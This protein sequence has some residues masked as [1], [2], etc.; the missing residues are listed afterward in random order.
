[1]PLFPSPSIF[2]AIGT[3][4]GTFVG[5]DGASEGAIFV[6]AAL[7][8][9]L[10]APTVLVG[11]IAGMLLLM[12]GATTA[13][14]RVAALGPNTFDKT[15]NTRPATATAIKIHQSQLQLRA[16]LAG[17]LAG[18]LVGVFGAVGDG[19][20]GLTGRVRAVEVVAVLRAAGFLPPPLPGPVVEVVLTLTVVLVVAAP[21][22]GWGVGRFEP[23]VGLWPA[24]GFA[25]LFPFAFRAAAV[26][27]AWLVAAG[28][29][30]VAAGFVRFMFFLSGMGGSSESRPATNAMGC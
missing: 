20:P 25:G 8:A 18:W 28:G 9:L 10:T 11:V 23:V 6:A 22:L 4:A 13:L 26:I 17:C 24:A 14:G 3:A 30:S 29:G 12:A 16:F 19:V 2:I 1:L 7:T 21:A 5:A 27:G 15:N